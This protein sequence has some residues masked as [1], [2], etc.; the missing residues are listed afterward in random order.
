V[1]DEQHPGVRRNAAEDIGPHLLG[2]KPMPRDDRDYALEDYLG[3]H[4]RAQELSGDTTIAELVD[5]GWVTSWHG[6][7]AFW[8]WLKQFMHNRPPTP[9]PT[10]TPAPTP[11]A[12]DQDVEWELG[13]IS[14][15]GQTPHC[16]GFTGLDWGNAEP[17]N[18]GWPNDDGHTIYYA[19][20]VKDGEPKEEDGSD[21]RSL[22]K[23]LKDMG[24][25]GAYAFTTD[26]ATIRAFVR[27]HG[28][29]GIGIPWDNDMFDPDAD[30][31]VRPG[32]GE[33][34]GHEIMISGHLPNGRGS[35][36]APSFKVPNHWGESWADGGVCYMTEDD[37]QSLLDRGG[38]SWAGVELPMPTPA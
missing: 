24:R 36:A 13:P 1:T 29:V 22:C 33:A 9:D 2:R 30:G 6:I 3:S 17:I 35:T 11:P 34:G 21:S 23:V 14:D 7:L 10:P 32:G 38:D 20:K 31:Y 8:K 26:V 15:Q 4:Q 12:D 27:E 19:C 28:P 25:I 18:D 5:G 16:V 37:L